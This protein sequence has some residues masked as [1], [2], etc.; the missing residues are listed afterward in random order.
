MLHFNFVIAIDFDYLY[1]ELLLFWIF[2]K[3]YNYDL[4]SYFY[5]M[6]FANLFVLTLLLV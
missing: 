1:W 6:F 4:R 5:L 2:G 3:N